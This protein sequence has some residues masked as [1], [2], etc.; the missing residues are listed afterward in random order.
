MAEIWGAAI[1]VGGAVLSSQAAK[2]KADK[3]RKEGRVDTKQAAKYEGILSAFEKEQDYYYQQLEKQE[4][5]RGLDQFKHF[6]TMKRIDPTYVNTNPGPVLPEKPDI[7]KM[8]EDPADPNAGNGGK[9][10]RS[11]LDKLQDFSIG[12]KLFGI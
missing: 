9:K 11:T 1:M 2:K 8:L 3:D 7:N 5:M 10:D 12:H 4:K 6:N